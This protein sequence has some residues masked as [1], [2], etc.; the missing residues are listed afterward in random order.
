MFLSS[1]VISHLFYPFHRSLTSLS[2]IEIIGDFKKLSQ[3]HTSDLYCTITDDQLT[4]H[5]YYNFESNV[6]LL[7]FLRI[8]VDDDLGKYVIESKRPGNQIIIKFC[9]EISK[10]SSAV[11][12]IP[13]NKSPLFF[14]GR[15]DEKVELFI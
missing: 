13:D 6:G 1:K 14:L 7:Y 5:N 8:L 9:E 2:L 3:S 12:D 11:S 15:E 4:F 10:F